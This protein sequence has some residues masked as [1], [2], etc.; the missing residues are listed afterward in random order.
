[1]CFFLLSLVLPKL[2]VEVLELKQLLTMEEFFFVKICC[3]EDP[4][5]WR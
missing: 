5:L 1:M 4:E 3:R 2:K